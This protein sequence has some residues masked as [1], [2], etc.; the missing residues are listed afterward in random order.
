MSSRPPISPGVKQTVGPVE[1]TVDGTVGHNGEQLIEFWLPLANVATFTL[2]AR[3]LERW[4]MKTPK[5]YY[6]LDAALVIKLLQEHGLTRSD[7]LAAGIHSK[8]IRKLRDGQPV[9]QQTVFRFLDVLRLNADDEMARRL[10]YGDSATANSDSAIGLKSWVSDGKPSEWKTAGNGLQYC[11]VTL[12]HLHTAD[13]R[14][15]GK[16]YDLSQFDDR[17]RQRIA[18]AQSRHP[19][20][21][22]RLKRRPAFPNHLDSGYD[23]TDEDHFWVIDGHEEGLTLTEYLQ[24]EELAG[25]G[26]SLAEVL[27]LMEQVAR[28]LM[29]L[30]E[31]KV[32]RRELTPD[33]I[34]VRPDGRVL[35]TDLE[36]CKLLGEHPTVVPNRLPPSTWLAPELGGPGYDD[37]VDVYSWGKIF[38]YVATGTVPPVTVAARDTEIR[39]YPKAIRHLLAN[40]TFA[41]Y[42]S[43]PT[44]AGLLGV[45]DALHQDGKKTSYPDASAT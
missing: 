31:A 34:L 14:A 35:L 32:I 36:L 12:R 3:E 45:L 16:C 2:S 25:G 37:R 8:S 9:Q 38:L 41:G 10:M 15:R 6:V 44:I 42:R 5:G 13:T 39:G 4:T 27:D 23:D 21:L 22:Q 7:L 19:N 28:A 1:G 30:H 24:R 43:R 17:A 40:A 11:V 33:S 20:V 18:P 29:E 26:L